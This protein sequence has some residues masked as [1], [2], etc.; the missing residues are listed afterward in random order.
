MPRDPILEKRPRAGTLPR[1]I[2]KLAALA[3]KA[4]RA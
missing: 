3:K 1:A 2:L 4:A